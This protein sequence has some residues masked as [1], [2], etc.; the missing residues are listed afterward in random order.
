MRLGLVLVNGMALYCF[1]RERWLTFNEYVIIGK[2]RDCFLHELQGVK[3]IIASDS[4]LFR[5]LRNLFSHRIEADL[6]AEAMKLFYG[7]E[8]GW[9]FSVFKLPPMEIRLYGQNFEE[10]T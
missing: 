9:C 1:Q 7:Y 2:D 6:A 10:R 3:S 8:M 5:C 4:P